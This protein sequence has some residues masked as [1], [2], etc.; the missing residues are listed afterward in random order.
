MLAL[1]ALYGIVRHMNRTK[2]YKIPPRF[3]LDHIARGCG[4]TGKILHS[5]KNYLL[6]ELDRQALEDLTSDALYYIE[7]ADTFDPP[8]TGLISSARATLK[9]IGE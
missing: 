3:Y 6:V 5:T 9:N 2:T 1:A 8:L 7:C 4:E